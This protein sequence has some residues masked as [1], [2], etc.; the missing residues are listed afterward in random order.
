MESLIVVITE[1]VNEKLVVLGSGETLQEA[2]K[3]TASMLGVPAES[4][5]EKLGPAGPFFPA[6]FPR[7]LL[8][9]CSPAPRQFEPQLPYGYIPI[10]LRKE[11]VFRQ[12]AYA[13]RVGDKDTG[14]IHGPVLSPQE[15]LEIVG[16]PGNTIVRFNSDDTETVL[17]KW[18][19]NKWVTTR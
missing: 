7:A 8:E 16:Q 11:K 13:I 4:V 17:Y 10:V 6:K 1:I 5:E 18:S 3:K 2:I 19:R 15:M 12:T 9:K 14:F